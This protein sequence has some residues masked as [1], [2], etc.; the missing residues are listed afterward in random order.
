MRHVLL[1]SICFVFSNWYGLSQI[2]LLTFKTG[3]DAL[4]KISHLSYMSESQ[5]YPDPSYIFIIRVGYPPL[6]R[7]RIFLFQSY[8]L[9]P[10]QSPS[11]L[12]SM[13][14]TDAVF[15]VAFLQGWPVILPILYIH[16]YAST[17]TYTQ[18]HTYTSKHAHMD[19]CTYMWMNEGIQPHWKVQ[20]TPLTVTLLPGGHSELELFK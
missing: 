12:G 3:T 11:P 18:T 5:K 19:M 6:N 16:T 2:I 9:H 14:C 15:R 8:G 4:S 10:P 20:F 17:C 1:S 7:L 13:S